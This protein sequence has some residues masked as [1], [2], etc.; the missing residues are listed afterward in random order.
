M[1]D[2]NTTPDHIVLQHQLMLDSSE[3]KRARHEAWRMGFHNPGDKSRV[4]AAAEA[5]AA[6]DAA[7]C[8]KSP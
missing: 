8:P 7:L 1:I 5:L 6:F 3:L 2:T 4:E